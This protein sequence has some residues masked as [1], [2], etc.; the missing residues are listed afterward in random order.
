M[1]VRVTVLSCPAKLL[2]TKISPVGE[3]AIAAAS[4]KLCLT[5]KLIKY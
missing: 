1:G 5:S 3:V 4:L 2:P